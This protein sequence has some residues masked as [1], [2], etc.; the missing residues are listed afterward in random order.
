[1]HIRSVLKPVLLSAG[2]LLCG[3]GFAAAQTAPAPQAQTEQGGKMQ[4]GK[5]KEARAACRAE[6]GDAKGDER[7]TKMKTCMDAKRQA[8]GLPPRQDRAERKAKMKEAR[9]KGDERRTKMQD[10]IAKK[11]PQQAKV[12]A[13]HK[14]ARDKNLTR[15]TPE[16]KAA[17]RSCMTA[18]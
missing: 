15:Q 9:A 10:C 8:A 2:L 6:I 17:M 3:L 4:G 18:N 11:D 12:M 5:M 14:Q 1:M 7:K 16:F 13:C